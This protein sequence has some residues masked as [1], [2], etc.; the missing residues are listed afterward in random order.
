[1]RQEC[2]LEL[3]EQFLRTITSARLRTAPIGVAQGWSP[4]SY[5]AAVK[6]LQA[7]GYSYIAIGG[8][9]PLKTSQVLE[10]L[11]A[12]AKVRRPATRLHL[13][14]VTRLECLTDFAARGVASFDSTSPLRQAFKDDRDNYYTLERTYS[15]IRVPQTEGN[16]KL[17]RAIRAGRIAQPHARALERACLD[18]MARLDRDEASVDQALDA[19]FAF[20][21]LFDESQGEA[22]GRRRK[23]LELY[24]EVLLHRP[25]RSCPCSVCRSLGHHVILFRGAERNRRR[26]LHNVWTFYRR[27][28]RIKQNRCA[29]NA[30]PTA[31]SSQCEA[32][33]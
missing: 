5:A 19:L 21:A 16:P 17:E 28:Q 1:M 6:K 10:I 15:A 23:H 2:T 26:G 9:V 25:W 13:L 4:L 8:M 22:A 30:V 33:A 3:A 24:R 7:M 12:V 18:L 29:T 11:D 27:V 32:S 31:V 20:D 14:G